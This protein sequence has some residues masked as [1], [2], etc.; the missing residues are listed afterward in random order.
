VHIGAGIRRAFGVALLVVLTAAP[1]LFLRPSSSLAQTTSLR[2]I[3]DGELVPLQ[4]DAIVQ[5]GVVMAPYQGL[6]EPLGVRTT[7]DPQTE[8]LTLLGAAGDEMQLR[9]NDPYATVNGERRPIPI[10]L[11][12]VFGRV[13]IPVQWVFDTLGDIT[14]YDAATRTLSLSAQITGITWQDAG[15]GLDVHL[16]GTAPL[17]ARAIQLSGPDRIVIEVIGA[18]AKLDQPVLDVHEGPLSTVAVATSPSGT[19]IVLTLLGPV[20]YRFQSDPAGRHAVLTLLSPT[21]AAPTSPASPV[22]AG[23]ARIA[24]VTYE[25]TD[26]GGRLVVASTV[27]VQFTQHVLRNPDRIVLD[28]DNAI[29]VPVKQAIDVNDGL[30]TQIRAAQFHHAPDVVRIVVELARPTAFVLHAGADATQT[31]LDLGTATAIA[32]GVLPPQAAAPRGAVV[33]AIDP[34]HGG[35]DP[36]AIGPD[37]VRE[38]DVVLAIAEDLHALLAQ[39][40]VDTVMVRESDVFVP[41]DDRAVI[42]QRG[43]ATLF[44]SIHANAS[45]DPNAR[46]TQT[47]YYTPQSVP[48]AQAVLDEVS[49]AAGL[50][51]RGVTQARFEVLVDDAKIP[52][53]LVETAFVTNPREEQLL[54]DPAQQQIVAQGIMK[55]IQRYLAAQQSTAP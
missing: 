9:P 13:L 31:L 38:K 3:A 8:T 18:V 22:A 24:N 6:S 17:H 43:G 40:H 30:V 28:A 34:G 29:F 32:P 14:S 19:Q 47:F 11:V 41:L 1:S 2:V 35:S 15:D 33:V 23:E 4:G 26:G 46:G 21:A 52:A 16:D 42:A 50:T 55:G 5:N 53:I 20:T 27:P 25:H 54:K 39:Q 49:R 37:G 12:T 48:L 44:V 36:G 45:V 10:P 51:P 7:W